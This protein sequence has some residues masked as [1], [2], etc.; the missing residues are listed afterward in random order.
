MLKSFQHKLKLI[1]HMLKEIIMTL[2]PRHK[3]VIVLRAGEEQEWQ[4]TDVI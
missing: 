2:I 1:E 4:M 3:Y